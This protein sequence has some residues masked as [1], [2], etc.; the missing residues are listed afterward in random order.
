MKPSGTKSVSKE[1]PSIDRIKTHLLK[2]GDENVWSMENLPNLLQDMSNKGLTELVDDSY[3]I[4]QTRERKLVEEALAGLTSHC[5]PFSESETLV[6]PESQKSS[7]SLFLRKSLS[8]P[9]LPSAQPLTPKKP[10]KHPGDKCTHNLVLFQN[11]L[12]KMEEIKRFTKSN[13]RKFEKLEMALQNIS[14]KNNV[15]DSNN[16]NSPLLLEILKNRISNL[17]QELTE[18]DAIINF[19][20]KQENEANNNT[21][22]VNKTVTENDEILQTE[23]G[24]S[25]PSSNSKQKI[26]IQTEP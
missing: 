21:S 17:D 14:G 22:S 23:R 10:V 12:N 25:S 13:E 9:G 3:K 16:E 15:N 26:E 24:N 4:K 2:I 18:K 11:L 20:L 8:T 6:F 19:L 5:A 1:K 7:E